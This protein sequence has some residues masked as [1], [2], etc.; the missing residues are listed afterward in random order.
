MSKQDDFKQLEYLRERRKAVTPKKIGSFIL[1]QK[2]YEEIKKNFCPGCAGPMNDPTL[3][4][5]ENFCGR[6]AYKFA[7]GE[8]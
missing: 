6:C 7:R 8:R 3:Y 5:G 2:Q 1:S 4:F